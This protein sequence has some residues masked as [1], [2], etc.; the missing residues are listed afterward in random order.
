MSLYFFTSLNLFEKVHEPQ[1]GGG[2]CLFLFV[3]SKELGEFLNIFWKDLV[4]KDEASGN[5][6]SY[7]GSSW[8]DPKEKQNIQQKRPIVRSLR[9]SAI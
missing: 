7:Q 9:N 4:W 8:G 1:V 2:I 5:E 3:K 6:V